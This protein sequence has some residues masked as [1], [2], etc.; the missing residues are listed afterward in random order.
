MEHY[1]KQDHLHNVIYQG[2]LALRLLKIDEYIATILDQCLL[3][4][5]SLMYL[6]LLAQ[7]KTP[8]REQD[9][10]KQYDFDREWRAD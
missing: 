9:D 1:R 2:V 8:Q 5:N 4:E 10:H 3:I 6:G 7:Q